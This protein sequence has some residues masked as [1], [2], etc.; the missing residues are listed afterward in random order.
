MK[1]NSKEKKF[2]KIFAPLELSSQNGYVVALGKC[3]PQGIKFRFTK[4][5]LNSRGATGILM[6]SK[7]W[8]GILVVLRSTYAAECLVCSTLIELWWSTRIYI[9]FICGLCIFSKWW[10]LLSN[11]GSPFWRG[12]VCSKCSG[13]W[14]PTLE[15]ICG[16]LWRILEE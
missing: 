8:R 12:R 13:K 4:S 15:R 5:T 14:Q 11:G 16:C 2:L 6:L 9:I 1:T 3:S 10:P 7:N